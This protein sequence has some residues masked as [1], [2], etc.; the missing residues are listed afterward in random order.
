MQDI[1]NIANEQ[2]NAH[3]L[4]QDPG[5]NRGL[6]V[7]DASPIQSRHQGIG[8][9]NACTTVADEDSRILQRAARRGTPHMRPVG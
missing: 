6:I 9:L 7:S 4:A 5:L 1:W 3:C 2:F 8:F